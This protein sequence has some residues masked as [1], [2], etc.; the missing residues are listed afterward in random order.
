ME[1]QVLGENE[2]PNVGQ[3]Q[4]L[5]QMQLQSR[6]GSLSDEQAANLSKGG[7][8][9]YGDSSNVQDDRAVRILLVDD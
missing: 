8:E 3:D 2:S 1:E 6:S 5:P 7:V 4:D 9:G